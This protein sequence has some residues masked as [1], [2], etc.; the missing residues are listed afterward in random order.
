MSTSFG[1]DQS[2]VKASRELSKE[3]EDLIF[4]EA[5]Y[6][7]AD[8]GMCVTDKNGRFVR[9]NAAYCRTYGYS[10]DELVGHEFTKVLPPEI[11]TYAANIHKAFIDGAPESAG[12]WQVLRK[13]GETRDIWV[14]AARIVLD[15]ERRFKVTT[16]T[17]ITERKQ[18]E[19]RVERLAK[20]RQGL[21]ELNHEVLRQPFDA[22]IYTKLLS[23][24]EGLVP[25]SQSAGLLLYD[26]VDDGYRFVAVR[27]YTLQ[28]LQSLRFGA[29]AL[30]SVG[31]YDQP[32]RIAGFAYD[33]EV[34]TPEQYDQMVSGGRF[35]EARITLV[36]PVRIEGRPV[37][38][39]MLE[40]YDNQHAFDDEEIATASVL[41]AQ[42][43]FI[44]RRIE[45][46]TQL[47]HQARHD[48]LTGLPNRVLMLDRLEQALSQA[49]RRNEAIAVFFIDLDDF[50]R[51]NDALGHGAGDAVLRE[52]GERL[53]GSLR[54]DDTVARLGG[55]EFVL[56]LPVAH[57]DDVTQLAVKLLDLFDRDVDLG[58]QRVHVTPSI[59]V[60][61]FPQD[62]SSP[63]E[64]IQ[65]ADAALYVAKEQGKNSYHYFNPELEQIALERITIERDLREALQGD[66]LY[67][68]YQPRYRLDDDMPVAAEALLR[69]NHPDRG[70]L[71]PGAFIPLAEKSR[72][73][74]DLDLWVVQS[75]V[76]RVR[77]WRAQGLAVTLS[78]NL[79]SRWLVNPRIQSWLEREAERFDGAGLELEITETSLLQNLADAVAQLDFYKAL[80][81]K[82][83]IAI[84]DFGTGHSSLSYLRN[85]PVD[86][87]KIDRS[88]LIDYPDPAVPDAQ[89]NRAVLAAIIRLGR[90]IGLSVVVEGVETAGQLQLLYELDADEAQGFHLA[91]PLSQAAFEALATPRASSRKRDV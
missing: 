56:I 90:D 57:G 79:S 45:L 73:I 21:L 63:D 65:A 38:L 16:V 40:N 6:N 44:F 86:T 12:E 58:D 1:S 36:I 43:A 60:S 91:I 24:V 33:R 47:A 54:S 77:A 39:L 71:M 68:D 61:L 17:D 69:W 82:L 81:P 4:L 87:L 27:G 48:A 18:N 76:A 66:D 59:G 85:L 15:D 75:S 26:D 22:Q 2:P 8:T 74:D 49:K 14:T 34:V 72:L 78:C 20:L 29:R 88:F 7:S 46:E 35:A 25:S 28:A 50:K 30:A 41:S 89:V 62:G 11:R 19:A 23:Y 42:M 84:D 64:L 67:F 51:I 55:D 9:V 13:D 83:R 31:I 3:N 32:K 80:L 10:R 53:R 52:V 70:R 37:A 5:I